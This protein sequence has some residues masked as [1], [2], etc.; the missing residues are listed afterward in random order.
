[1]PFA[2][3]PS[4][5]NKNFHRWKKELNNNLK[6]EILESNRGERRELRREEGT[7]ERGGN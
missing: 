7:E 1:M 3:R 4:A 6:S 5:N 2:N